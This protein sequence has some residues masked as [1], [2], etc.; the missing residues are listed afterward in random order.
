MHINPVN[1]RVCKMFLTGHSFVCL[2]RVFVEFID[3]STVFT[4]ILTEISPL[5]SGIEA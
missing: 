4:V 2:I 1:L 5:T 3:F